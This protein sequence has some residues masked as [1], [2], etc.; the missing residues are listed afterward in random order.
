MR[1]FRYSIKS[2]LFLWIF[3]FT[4]AL[5][6]IRGI[7]I[8]HETKKSVFALVEN[9]LHTKIQ[10]L[11]GLLHVEDGRIEL[12]HEL[13]LSGEYS[14]PRSGYYYK[15]L[16]NG[17]VL[18]A[19]LS[20][21]GEDLNLTSDELKSHDPKIGESIYASTGPDKEP[22][23]AIKHDFIIFNFPVTII[24]AQTLKEDILLIQRFSNFLITT[25]AGSIFIVVLMGLWIARQSLKPLKVF[26]SAIEK[27][28]HKTMDD[29]I[30]A[31]FQAEEIKGLA[32]SF[33]SMLDRLKNA[34][35]SEKRL[36]AD[37]SHELKTPVSVIKAQ[38][39][40]MLQKERTN[41]EYKEAMETIRNVA[42]NMGKAINDMLSL[43]RLDSGILSSLN[44]KRV[45]LSDSLLKTVQLSEPLAKKK[46]VSIKTFI[47]SDIHVNGDE[48]RITEA[49]LNIIENAVNYN[50]Q[51][52]LVE[53]SAEKRGSNAN[54][55]VSDTGIGIREDDL[56][57]IFKRFCRVD[58]SYKSEGSGLGLSITRT[59]IETHGGN[60]KVESRE[61]KGS[62]FYITLPLMREE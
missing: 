38:C 58:T 30:D 52:G 16:V 2:R 19:S 36:F 20:M 43:A 11:K 53:V 37:A 47:E 33:N 51:G 55:S 14:I 25:I 18:D 62:C 45:S 4:S 5:L 57:K 22:V 32:R 44:F 46:L 48:E 17:K 31:E 1:G 27:I 9:K 54:I 39:D 26:S 41:D 15:V 50:K 13:I 21:A 29:R 24:A 23:L 42:G 49:F 59:I 34:F 12:K 10:I 61:G 56:D 3:L 28:T 7:A 40:V 35:D 60:I 6:I 8:Y